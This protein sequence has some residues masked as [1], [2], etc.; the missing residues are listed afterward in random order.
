MTIQI[1]RFIKKIKI[2]MSVV[3]ASASFVSLLMV[4]LPLG[5]NL[6]NYLTY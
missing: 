2:F 5:F 3:S 1:K 6:F 4:C